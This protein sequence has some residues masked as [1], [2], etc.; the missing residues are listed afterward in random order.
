MTT[1]GLRFGRYEVGARLGKGGFGVVHVARDTELGRD[2]AIKFLKPEYLMRPQIVQRFLQ[3]ARAAAKI[4]HAGIVTVFE[5]GHVEGTNLRVDGTAFIAMELLRGQSLADRLL[6]GGRFSAAKAIAVARQLADALGAAHAASIIHRDLKPDNVFLVPDTAIVG[7]ERVKVLDFG[8]A[9]LAEPADQGVHTHSQM[10]LGTPRYMSPEQS[11]S[12]AKID[13]RSDIYT[14]GCILFELVAGRTPFDGDS[15][16]LIAKHQRDPVPDLRA[17]APVPEAYASLVEKMLAKSP[18][19]RPQTMANVAAALAAMDGS[20]AEPPPVSVARPAEA[21]TTIVHSTTARRRRRIA[22]AGGGVV[23]A[24]IVLALALGGGGG[25]KPPAPR[26][27][28]VAVAQAPVAVSEAA[29]VPDAASTFPSDDAGHQIYVT[30]LEAKARR[31]WGDLGGCADELAAHDPAT[32]A[33]LHAT[34]V[35]EAKAQVAFDK[36]H[37]VRD[38]ATAVALLAQIPE[39]SVYRAEASRYAHDH[40]EHL[41]SRATSQADPPAT[42]EPACN[43]QALKTKGERDYTEGD[44]RG[45]MRAFKAAYDCGGGGENQILARAYQSACKGRLGPDAHALF[46][47][48]PR[49]QQ[50]NAQL[51]QICLQVS[52]DPRK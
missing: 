11:R 49:A 6:D 2:I 17:L 23:G 10:L 52:I 15:G 41:P 20:H 27:A 16:E 5:C 34:A 50:S 37:T 14:L 47:L 42:P 7:G 44:F 26:D 51:I 25:G 39:D 4:G 22:L 31:N 21:D 35:R 28:A 24:G 18:D 46:E 1:P 38:L 12:A 33:L 8:V 9:K 3:E 45:A 30:C 32:A 19:A 40:V 48:L 43:E 36:L 29:P 13:T